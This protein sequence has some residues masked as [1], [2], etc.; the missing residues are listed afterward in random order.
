MAPNSKQADPTSP[1]TVPAVAMHAADCTMQDMNP[2]DG[3]SVMKRSAIGL[4]IHKQVSSQTSSLSVSCAQ[5][6]SCEML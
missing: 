3:R 4:G 1:P 2:T 5:V 6:W